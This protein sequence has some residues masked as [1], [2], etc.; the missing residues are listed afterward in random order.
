MRKHE[1]KKN[2]LSE[3]I[4]THLSVNKR[5]AG[6]IKKTLKRKKLRFRLLTQTLGL[7]IFPE[8]PS[9]CFLGR[10]KGSLLAG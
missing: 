1:G 6:L 8:K 3:L 5:K 7:S 4:M 10:S 2:E 9:F